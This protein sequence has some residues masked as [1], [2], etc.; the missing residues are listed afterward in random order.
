MGLQ[1]LLLPGSSYENGF[2]RSDPHCQNSPWLC[3]H[4]KKRDVQKRI[5]NENIVEHVM[6]WEDGPG[7]ILTDWGKARILPQREEKSFNGTCLTDMSQG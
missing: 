2:T 3:L 6:N 1:S 5:E 7:G 4:M